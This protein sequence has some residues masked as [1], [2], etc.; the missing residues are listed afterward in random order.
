MPVAPTQPT[1]G[2]RSCTRC[3]SFL[4]DAKQRAT[5]GSDISGPI[6]GSKMLPLVMP[7][8]PRDAK[9]RAFAHQAKGCNKFGIDV[10]LSELKPES[11][12]ILN[13]GGDPDA[14]AQTPDDQTNARCGDCVFFVT[15]K[16]VSENTGWTSSLCRRNGTLMLDTRLSQYA[17]Y[18]GTF[19]RRIGPMSRSGNLTKFVFMPYLSPTFGRVDAAAEYRKA[20]RNV[21][22]PLDY[23]TDREVTPAQAN[24]GIQAWRRIVDPEGYGADTYLPIYNPES[25]DPDLRAL[26]P[27][28]E[29]DRRPDLYAD[30]HGYLYSIA[31]LWRELD[32]APAWWGQGGVGKTE[33]GNYLAWLMQSPFGRLSITAASELDDVMGKMRFENNETIFQYGRLP[34]M[35]RRPGVILLDEPNT[36]PNDL[37]QAIRPLTDN[38]KVLVLDQNRGERIPRGPDTYLAL[39]MNPD[40]SPLNIGTNALGDADSSRLMHMFFALPPEDIEKEIIQA[41]LDLDGWELDLAR[42][43]SLMGVAKDLRAACE[44]GN[45][46]SSWGIRHQIKVA[47][48]LKWWP[49]VVAYR[50]AIA[51]ALEPQQLELVLGCVNA[52]F[53]SNR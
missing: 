23:Q 44:N 46:H 24:R 38:S 7:L 36:G 34:S 49:P 1:V 20:A 52:H 26:V 27:K 8:Q 31:V 25:F 12:P 53:A 35:W 47:R 11:A 9:E 40:W 42:M 29:G 15:S 3:P 33:F 13:V 17:K 51:D 10:E 19:K 43:K 48:A 21:Q 6:C 50:R 30:H 32:E 37:W 2:G 18:C 22:N 41:R 16:E 39:A 28:I 14:L 45:L 5:M 4:A